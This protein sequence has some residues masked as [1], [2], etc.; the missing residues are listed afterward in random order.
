M[1]LDLCHVQ[2]GAEPEPSGRGWVSK[3]SSPDAHSVSQITH[4]QKEPSLGLLSSERGSG[5]GS[6]LAFHG[7]FGALSYLLCY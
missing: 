6:F 5:C 7:L 4:L 2:S 1:T 3:D